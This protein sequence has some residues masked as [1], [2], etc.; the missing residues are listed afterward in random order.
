MNYLKRIKSELVGLCRFAGW[1]LKWHIVLPRR[2]SHL[3]SAGPDD[4]QCMDRDAGS[5]LDQIEHGLVIFFWRI[6]LLI[7][8]ICELGFLDIC[9]SVALFCLIV[10]FT[11][12]ILDYR[13]H[14]LFG[15]VKRF[16]LMMCAGKVIK[17]MNCEVVNWVKCKLL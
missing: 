9:H 10:C 15:T 16:A 1:G 11:L 7:D 14:Q 5:R 6:F 3:V 2:H 4:V 8:F 13:R 17:V 12:R